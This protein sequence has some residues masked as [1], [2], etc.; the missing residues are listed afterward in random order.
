[1]QRLL[2]LLWFVMLLCTM[3]NYI[4]WLV[5][6][7]T[8]SLLLLNGSC[9]QCLHVLYTH[10]HIVS[11]FLFQNL[12]WR[13]LD[14]ILSRL[15]NAMFN[16]DR[17]LHDFTSY[18]LHLVFT[19]LFL[20]TQPSKVSFSFFSLIISVLNLILLFLWTCCIREVWIFSA[21]SLNRMRSIWVICVVE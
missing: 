9:C 20:L 13:S 3:M 15:L 11:L 16:L 10:M 14:R 12:Y 17:G 4:Y 6:V 7:L 18:T 1:M 8:L 5:S 21:A 19:S 2:L